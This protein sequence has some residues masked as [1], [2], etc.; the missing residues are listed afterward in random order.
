MMTWYK[1]AQNES[2]E[3]EMSNE[4]LLAYSNIVIN[5]RSKNTDISTDHTLKNY[6]SLAELVRSGYAPLAFSRCM[7]KGAAPWGI[8]ASWLPYWTLERLLRDDEYT[9]TFYSRHSIID[10]TRT[11]LAH[12]FMESFMKFAAEDPSRSNDSLQSVISSKYITSD[13]ISRFWELDRN[14][15]EKSSRSRGDSDWM[16]KAQI[17]VSLFRNQNT[18]SNIQLEI[19]RLT[20]YRNDSFRWL[21]KNPNGSGD[22]MALMLESDKKDSFSRLGRNGVKNMFNEILLSEKIS[23]SVANVISSRLLKI[24]SS[25]NYNVYGK[26]LTDSHH[27]NSGDMSFDEKASIMEYVHGICMTTQSKAAMNNLFS[28]VLAMGGIRQKEHSLEPLKSRHFFSAYTS[29]SATMSIVRMLSTFV[30]NHEKMDQELLQKILVYISSIDNLYTDDVM[31]EDGMTLVGFDTP[32]IIWSTFSSHGIPERANAPSAEWDRF[33]VNS[34]SNIV[35]AVKKMDMK[36]FLANAEST[37]MDKLK[38]YK[39]VISQIKIKMGKMDSWIN[40][41]SG[42]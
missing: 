36:K 28:L 12:W 9:D 32:G 3:C 8:Y 11:N 21:V 41:S 30:V 29:Q 37:G 31:K 34:K 7:R 5:V 19:V 20:G 16:K 39:I 24:V 22:A 25:K 4:D 14:E 10:E 33:V 42:L 2:I 6:P 15:R 18:P 35:N 40:R 38:V 13:M 1:S 23:D 26:E 27:T 17:Y